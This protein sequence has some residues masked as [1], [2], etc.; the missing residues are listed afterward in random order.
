MMR[1]GFIVPGGLANHS[2]GFLYDR[3]LV[4]HLRRPGAHVDVIP[5]KWGSYPGDLLRGLFNA[6]HRGF[7][8][9]SLDVLL[10]D[11]LSHPRLLS[12][13]RSLR[14]EAGLPIISVVHHLRSSEPGPSWITSV[15]LR[16]YS[17]NLRV[18]F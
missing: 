6:S 14:R 1:I 3:M 18:C 16:A 5:L 9:S 17:V 15:V 10:E 2:G 12:F 8:P 13:N 4:E 11:E 7:D